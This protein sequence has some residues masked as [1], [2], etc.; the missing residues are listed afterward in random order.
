METSNE[1]DN[2]HF[3]KIDKDIQLILYNN[4]NKVTKK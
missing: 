4:R 2:K 3:K 1:N